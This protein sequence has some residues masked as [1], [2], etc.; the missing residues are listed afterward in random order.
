M[1]KE[2]EE[3]LKWC[4]ERINFYEEEM[5]VHTQFIPFSHPLFISVLETKKILERKLKLQKIKNK[6]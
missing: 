2:E 3:V 5:K 6:L 1:N 4:N